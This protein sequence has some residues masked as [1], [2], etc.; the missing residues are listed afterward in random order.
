[1]SSELPHG[2]VVDNVQGTISVPLGSVIIKFS[3]QEWAEFVE[4]VDDINIVFQANLETS[5]YQC[6]ACGTLNATQE[7]L[8][9][10]DEEIH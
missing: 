9:P 6:S 3:F 10:E 7:Y 2:A 4:I 1:M 8:E 5:V